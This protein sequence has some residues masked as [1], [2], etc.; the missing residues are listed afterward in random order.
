MSS[1]AHDRVTGSNYIQPGLQS[2]RKSSST[3]VS[4]LCD[5]RSIHSPISSS[6]PFLK[7]LSRGRAS[8]SASTSF[9]G[10]SPGRAPS[11]RRPGRG[12]R[13]DVA[14]EAA[15][16]CS[17][18]GSGCRGVSL[19]WNPF[20]GSSSVVSDRSAPV[21]L[22]ESSDSGT[23]SSFVESTLSVWDCLCAVPRW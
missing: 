3:S 23:D 11:E 19:C 22:P 4:H 16:S 18:R 14:W 7:W 9:C 6:S 17:P 8:V 21:S 2:H 15:E 5:P 1:A 20:H 12:R 13:G 10:G